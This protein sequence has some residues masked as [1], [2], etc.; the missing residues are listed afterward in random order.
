[1]EDEDQ[2]ERETLLDH[3][4]NTVG[5]PID[6]TVHFEKNESTEVDGK[7]LT[8]KERIKAASMLGIS[9]FW[10]ASMSLVVSVLSM[11]GIKWAETTFYCGVTGT[12]ISWACVARFVGLDETVSQ[13]RRMG[14]SGVFW[15]TIL[16]GCCVTSAFF[17]LNYMDLADANVLMFTLPVW[18]GIFGSFLGGKAWDSSTILVSMVGLMGVILVVRPSFI[19]II[20]SASSRSNTWYGEVSAIGFGISNGLASVIIG[21][22][23]RHFNP[24]I[25]T[26]TYFMHGPVLFGLVSMAI[27]STSFGLSGHGAIYAP[28]A[29]AGVGLLMF[30][31]MELRNRGLKLAA[32]ETSLANI[33]YLEIACSFCWNT[34]YLGN[35]FSVLSFSG[36]LLIT[37]SAALIAI[38]LGSQEK[39]MGK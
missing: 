23:D 30:V 20:G 34:F 29:L 18:A 36:C 38:R 11:H 10:A 9:A 17:A 19:P 15:R 14:V 2:H 21:M 16:G 39:K 8:F 35:A 5:N 37:G 12:L 31:S 24:F 6:T 13:Y 25:I 27:T 33:L 7:S 1:M 32:A 28:V 22:F 26:T 4:T 3:P